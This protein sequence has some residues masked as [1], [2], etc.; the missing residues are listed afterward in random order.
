VSR[1]DAPQRGQALADQVLV[2]R[3]AVVGQGF[4]VGK[5]R[6]AQLGG[7]EGHL[8]DQALGVAGIGRDDGRDAAR[9]PLALR[10]ARQQ[11]RIG[12][13]RGAGQ[14]ETLTGRRV[15]SCMGEEV[16]VAPWAWPFA[17][18]MSAKGKSRF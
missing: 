11:Q 9:R 8:V 17:A 10:Q 14:G 18:R 13:A 2:R 4:P 15:G 1:W 5:Q 6:A 12:A 7:E 16:A 3:E